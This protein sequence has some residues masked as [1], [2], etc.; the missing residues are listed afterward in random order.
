MPYP[1]LSAAKRLIITTG[2]TQLH[3]VY[4]GD[5]TISIPTEPTGVTFTDDTPSAGWL[6]IQVNGTTASTSGAL[7]FTA[8]DLYI[9][10]VALASSVESVPHCC[11][12]A[13]PITWFNQIGGW[14]S[15]GFRKKRTFT[16]EIGD[17]V[18]Q[19]FVSGL[20]KK[21]ADIGDVYEG[22]IIDFEIFSR[23]HIETISKMR[24]SIQCFTY[25]A[26]NFDTPILIERQSFDKYNNHAQQ[27]KNNISFRF[28]YSTKLNIQG[29]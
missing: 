10:V 9:T 16:I 19:T 11:T 23:T 26:T 8:F 29:Q 25:G 3:Y 12:D 15:W 21:Y 27:K 18:A 17:Q 4:Y 13:L 28:I 20:I 5:N 2:S 24:Y 6:K 1:K 22:E 14:Q 7:D